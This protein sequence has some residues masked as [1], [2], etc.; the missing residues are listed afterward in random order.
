MIGAQSYPLDGEQKR[1]GLCVHILPWIHVGGL[2]NMAHTSL[3]Q[4]LG[5]LGCL[6]TAFHA[7]KCTI[8]SDIAFPGNW[9]TYVVWVWIHSP[10][11]VLQRWRGVPMSSRPCSS[12]REQVTELK[13]GASLLSSSMKAT[14]LPCPSQMVQC[15]GENTPDLLLQSWVNGSTGRIT[16]LTSLC[17]SMKFSFVCS[18]LF[19][20]VTKTYVNEHAKLWPT[21]TSISRAQRCQLAVKRKLRL[22]SSMLRKAHLQ[23]MGSLL[24]FLVLTSGWGRVSCRSFS[25]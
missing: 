17:N 11:K 1:T 20:A 9:Q 8:K 14:L 3:R 25:I 5:L 2:I 19:I 23:S 18:D 12:S 13:T 16:A 22:S 6:F 10:E 24:A 15:L 4:N 7:I 21:Q